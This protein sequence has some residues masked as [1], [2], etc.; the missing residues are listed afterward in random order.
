MFSLIKGVLGSLGRAPKKGG[1][2][3]GDGGAVEPLGKAL[4]LVLKA[5]RGGGDGS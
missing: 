1:R 4:Q 2:R 5:Q 3:G